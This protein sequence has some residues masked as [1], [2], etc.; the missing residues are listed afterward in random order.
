MSQVTGKPTAG[1]IFDAV[2]GPKD[3]SEILKPLQIPPENW[4]GPITITYGQW[5][6]LKELTA[7]QDRK[8]NAD[9]LVEIT[10]GEL[11]ILVK[12]FGHQAGHFLHLS[13]GMPIAGMEDIPPC[14]YK[15]LTGG[16]DLLGLDRGKH[17]IGNR[18][19]FDSMN[20]PYVLVT[21]DE[22]ET[23]QAF[24]AE[25]D[26]AI[27][28]ISTHIRRG[29][30]TQWDSMKLHDSNPKRVDRNGFIR[31]LPDEYRQLIDYYE[32]AA[33]RSEEIGK[34]ANRAGGS[35]WGEELGSPHA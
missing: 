23:L 15:Q 26:R 12:Y 31:V 27:E 14:F 25:E 16:L 35:T 20:G 22:W 33:T 9:F 13:A 2:K 3:L 18:E 19:I 34:H 29:M 21:I 8:P 5:L 30:R 4:E 6:I 32:T 24:R 17:R 7:D 28:A 11:E 10:R 1:S